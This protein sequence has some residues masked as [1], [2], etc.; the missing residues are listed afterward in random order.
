MLLNNIGFIVATLNLG[1]H[2]TS[3]EA[4]YFA[5]LLLNVT[6]SNVAARTERVLSWVDSEYYSKIKTQL[7]KES[8]NLKKRAISTHFTTTRLQGLVKN[9]SVILHGN[10]RILH[11]DSVKKVVPK[12]FKLVFYFQNGR[13]SIKQFEEVKE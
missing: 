2:T 3:P 4:Y 1:L 10:L 8:E 5:T 11:G 9:Q 13:P 6:P 12:T 7:H